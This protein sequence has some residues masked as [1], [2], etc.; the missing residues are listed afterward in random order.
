MLDNNKTSNFAS[1]LIRIDMDRE[2]L[3]FVVDDDRVIRNFLEYTFLGKDN[4]RIKTFSTVEECF[5][6]LYL[7]PNLIVL[8]HSFISES[9]T[10]MTGLDALKK[11]RT[12]DKHTSVIILSSSTDEILIENYKLNGASAFIHKEGYFINTLLDV[13]ETGEMDE[14]AYLFNCPVEPVS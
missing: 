10:L 7:Q 8:D 14:F 2:K 1:N 11:I 9:N 3:V 13:I 6:N 5:E 12:Q 4:Y